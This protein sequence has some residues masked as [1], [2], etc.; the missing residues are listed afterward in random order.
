MSFFDLPESD[1]IK[2][3]GEGKWSI[4][5]IL[6]HLTDTEYLLMGRLKKVI[7]E[8]RQV[9]WGFNPD[10]WSAAFDYLNEPLTGKKEFY[11]LCREMNYQLIDR[12]FDQC[13]KYEFVHSETGLRTLEMEFEKVAFHNQSHN[14]QIE[15]ALKR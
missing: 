6:H 9:I 8:P 13:G 7:A 3:Y 5:Q 4:R 10:D 14:N 2:T 1:L 11:S 12:Y 15:L